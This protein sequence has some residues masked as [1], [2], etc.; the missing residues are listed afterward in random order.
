MSI[1]P[2]Y[3][4]LSDI[5]NEHNAYL[6]AV[7]PNM[8]NQNGVAPNNTEAKSVTEDSFADDNRSVELVNSL[9]NRPEIREAGY[10][11]R[12]MFANKKGK[13]PCDNPNC[14]YV[15]DEAGYKLLIKEL[16]TM[17]NK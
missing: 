16:S 7:E 8:R 11:T 9:L 17:Y 1:G 3:S 6:L 4:A 14:K 13:A 5:T 12:A 10:C 2:T 15:H